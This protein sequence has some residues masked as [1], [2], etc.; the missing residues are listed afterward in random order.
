MSTLLSLTN[1][2][3]VL[4]EKHALL[5]KKIVKDYKQRLNSVEYINAKK[6]KLKL[7]DEIDSLSHIIEIKQ[8]QKD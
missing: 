6:Q 2:L 7:K 1:H 4:K 8:T 3:S 5:D